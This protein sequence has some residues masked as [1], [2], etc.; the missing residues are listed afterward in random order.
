MFFGGKQTSLG[1]DIGTSAIK[2]VELQKEGNFIR[3]KNYAEYR[4]EDDSKELIT[5][6]SSMTPFS[7]TELSSILKNIISGANIETK[8]ANFSI[9]V[10]SSFLTLIEMPQMSE[11]EIPKA[12]EFQANKYIPVPLSEVFLNWVIIK[13]DKGFI[14]ESNQDKIEILLVAAPKDIVERYSKLAS[15]VGFELKLLEVENFSLA[16][17][18]ID[19]KNLNLIIDIGA[20][21]SSITIVDNGFIRLSSFLEFSGFH[22]TKAISER[23]K[24]DEA[25]AERLKIENGLLKKPQ[26]Q[27]RE[28]IL[29]LFDK[30]AFFVESAINTYLAK[31]PQKEFEKIILTGGSS[32]MPGIIE[33]FSEKFQISIERGNPFSKILCTSILKDHIQ[34]IAPTFSIACG[35]ALG[36]FEA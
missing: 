7:E 11:E 12:I 27:I 10:F 31:N 35:L 13:K 16:R 26:S 32:R 15:D 33:Y 24:V 3:L 2:M 6:R 14:R 19:T 8:R 25:R 1:I 17:S 20:R 30:L 29:P 28:A 36:E 9:P 34:E 22:F 5:F 18:L 21:T 4:P 23:I